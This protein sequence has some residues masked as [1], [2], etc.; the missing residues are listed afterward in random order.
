MT[1]VED[2][3][4][5]LKEISMSDAWNPWTLASM[6]KDVTT[7]QILRGG[8]SPG[9]SKWTLNAIAC[10]LTR[11]EAW[12]QTENS[13]RHTHTQEEVMWRQRQSLEWWICKP[14]TASRH[15]KLEEVRTD[16]PLEPPEGPADTS[17]WTSGL[18]Q[19]WEN[20]FGCFKSVV[21]LF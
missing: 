21:L 20:E 8:A 6:M 10:I 3:K 13:G 14:R 5:G 1:F 4:D 16:S 18:Q 12:G 7:F 15:Q 17:T 9:L 11:G 19:L 2:Q